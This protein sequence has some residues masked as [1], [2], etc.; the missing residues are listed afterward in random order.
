[1]RLPLTLAWRGQHVVV[2]LLVALSPA[3][4]AQT[5]TSVAVPG[6]GASAFTVSFD[7]VEIEKLTSDFVSGR[8][9]DITSRSLNFEYDYGLTDRLA[10]TASIPLRS[11]RAIS[12]GF[13]HDPTLLP[14]DHGEPFLDNGEYHSYWAD[15]GLS[16]RWQWRS[17][18]RLAVT[19]FVSYYTPSNHYPIYGLSQP[20]R[21]QW[22]WDV[23]L[24]ASGRLGAP[25]LNL[26]WKAGYAYSYFEKTRPA[27]APARRVN[28]SRVTLELG[29]RATPRIAPYFIIT[30][31]QPHNGVP[32]LG[33]SAGIFVS[34]QWYYHDWLF[35]WEQRTWTIG[36]A[37]QLS[38]D[39]GLSFAYGRSDKVKFGFYQEPAVSIGYTRAFG[40]GDR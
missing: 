29:W 14:D 2:L 5:I 26:Y 11:N 6:R 19:P 21:G 36:S 23:G 37:F 3:A 24:N 28:R 7:Y 4:R 17:A 12:Y 40:R 30:D 33:F 1:M 32:I 15:I 31:T 34:D 22:R 39:T 10:L 35:P 20:G 8:L 25:R 18:E 16:V 38:D 13:Q 27:D 9:V